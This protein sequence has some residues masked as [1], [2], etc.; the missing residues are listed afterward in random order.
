[1][2]TVPAIPNKRVVKIVR[3]KVY[4]NIVSV[5]WPCLHSRSELRLK[6]DK[7][8]TCTI[9]ANISDN[10]EAMV[11]T[12]GMAVGLCKACMIMPVLTLMQGHSG[13]AKSKYQCLNYLD[14]GTKQATSNNLANNDRPFFFFDV[15]LT[16]NFFI[17]LDHLDL[18]FFL[19][20]S[21]TFD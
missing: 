11:F 2:Q 13:S 9:I 16:L 5:R 20:D 21:M 17:W 14:N 10:I 18:C 6:F 4:N 19:S 7:C 15:T 3:L 12:F 1:M 8:L